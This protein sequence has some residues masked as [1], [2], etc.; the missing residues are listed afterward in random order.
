MMKIN[1]GLC[2][3]IGE[4]NFG[5]RGATV[6]LELE[7]DSSLVGE[8]AKLKERIRQLF[9]LLRTSLAEELNGGNA[10]GQAQQSNGDSQPPN[11]QTGNGNGNGHNTGA[12]NGQRSGGQRPATQSQV[13]A[14]YAIARGR[15]INV[16]QFLRERFQVG[17]PDDLSLKD[18]SAVIDELKSPDGSGE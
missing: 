7:L 13:K 14:I 17:R 6:N 10:N 9:A 16:A 3:K 15:Q 11:S 4:A 1:V 2:R 8:P 12:Q 5:S 18:A